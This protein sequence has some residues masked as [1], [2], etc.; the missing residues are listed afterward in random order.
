[1]KIASFSQNLKKQITI[2][3]RNIY[4]VVFGILGLF[5]HIVAFS[6]L[7]KIN[8]GQITVQQV[9][10]ES[11]ENKATMSTSINWDNLRVGV[12]DPPKPTPDAPIY[13]AT[14]DFHPAFLLEK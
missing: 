6:F 13:D 10:A 12:D 5:A 8:T 14:K 7:I 2:L 4:S 9:F 1:M 3:L 11:S